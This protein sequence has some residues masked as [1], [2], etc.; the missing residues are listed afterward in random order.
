[1]N[2]NVIAIVA[3]AYTVFFA[4]IVALAHRGRLMTALATAVVVL[5]TSTFLLDT[6]QTQ[7]SYPNKKVIVFA[8]MF[9]SGEGKQRIYEKAIATFEKQNPQYKVQV[10]WDGR[11]VLSQN[12]PRLLTGKDVPDIIE[13]SSEELRIIVQEQ[14][15]LPLDEHIN[16]LSP[17][18]GKPW[19]DDWDPDTLDMG[20]YRLKPLEPSTGH[21]VQLPPH[22]LEGK[23]ALAPNLLADSVYFYNKA[24]ARRLG[25]DKTP[26]TW[27]EFKAVCQKA[28]DAD[29]EPIMLEGNG[30]GSMLADTLLQTSVP[31]EE[32]R[33]TILGVGSRKPFTDL[34]YQRIYALEREILDKYVMRGWQACDWPKGQQAFAT[35]KGLFILCGTWLPAELRETAVTDKNI[36]ELGIIPF[37]RFND[38]P[39]G[40]W[41]TSAFGLIIL[42]DGNQRQG[43]IRFL[44][45]LSGTV[46]QE[47]RW[48]HHIATEDGNLVAFK[49]DPLPAELDDLRV[50]L[51]SRTRL[52]SN[53]TRAFAPNWT[54]YIYTQ[55]HD[56][57]IKTNHGEASY[58][59]A[60][61][62]LQELERRTMQ[63]NRA[64]G[65]AKWH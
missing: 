50:Q 47:D 46:R 29:V 37:P 62:F 58:M 56:D 64:G 28:K 40:I 32:L 51:A 3:V 49:R 42:K 20:R 63:Y 34:L 24:I 57:F 25:I 39:P 10:R 54:Q 44:Q 18:T 48:G 65:E 26:Q 45:F 35:G 12:R 15:A 31:C 21:S 61:Q 23:L 22:P 11:W 1:M 13:G 8:S 41:A 30:Y 59:T 38:E 33:Q 5:V 9:A 14:Y 19:K 17:E 60:G 43:A 36:F 53:P 7:V 16:A 4:G 52:V 55:L 27:D 2:T 6:F